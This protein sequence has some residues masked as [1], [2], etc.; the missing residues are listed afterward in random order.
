MRR[1]LPCD[2][3]PA[4]IFGNIKGNW[5][6]CAKRGLTLHGLPRN[7]QQVVPMY[8]EISIERCSIQKAPPLS[9]ATDVTPVPLSNAIV[10]S[11]MDKRLQHHSMGPSMVIGL[12]VKFNSLTWLKRMLLKLWHQAILAKDDL[13]WK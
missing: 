13:F 8:K 9:T 3:T 7:Q 1:N 12:D 11:P 4:I 6:T 5:L 2:R 10:R